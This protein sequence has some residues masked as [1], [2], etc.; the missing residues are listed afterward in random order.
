VSLRS[1]VRTLLCCV[2]LELGA[3]T[4][5]P[6]RPEEIRAMMNALAQPKLARTNPDR[7][8]DGDLPPDPE[9]QHVRIRRGWRL[10]PR[11][12]GRRAAST[13]PVTRWWQRLFW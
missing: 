8:D 2:V 1:R 13:R 3:L 6:M 5:V 7:P 4:G 11:P 9:D 10:L 12:P